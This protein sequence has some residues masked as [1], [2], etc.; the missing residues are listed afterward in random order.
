MTRTSRRL[1]LI[2]GL[3]ALLLAVGG[4][5]WASWTARATATGTVTTDA[6]AVSQTGF[7]APADTKYLPSRLTSTRSFTVTNGSAIPGAATVTIAAPQPYASGLPIRVWPVAGAAACTEATA[8]PGTGVTTGTWAS[9][10]LTPSLAAGSAVTYCVRTQIPNWRTITDGAGGQTV[11][12][13]LTVGIN[14]QGWTATTPTATHAQRTAGM[15]PLT[16]G[17]F[18]DAGLSRWHTIRS[19]G[20]SGLCLDVSDSGT[21]AGTNIIA[22]TCGPNSNQ[23]WEFVPVSGTNQQLVTLRPRNAPAMRVGTNAA[24]QLQLAAAA[25]A[26]AQQWYVQRTTSFFQLVSASTGLCLPV[27]ATAGVQNAV[28]CDDPRAQLLFVREPLTMSA[29]LLSVTLSFGSGLPASTL[30]R[31]DGANWTNVTGGSIANGATSVTFA[32]E[33]LVLDRTYS[34]RIVA[35]GGVVLYDNI[36]LRQTLLGGVQA[37]SGIG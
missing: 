36:S 37:I 10:T 26:P 33:L 20:A 7:A 9:A 32:R 8:V 16:V 31:L 27:N 30:Q 15:Y 4:M 11:N 14:A 17:N 3:V 22:W 25:T 19:P 5:A 13:V 21:A 28:E 1:P 6:V 12:P 34:F 2:A 29:G 18:Y 24:G 35:S 23:R